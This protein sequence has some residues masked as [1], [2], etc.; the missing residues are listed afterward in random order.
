MCR[1]LE[2]KLEPYWEQG[3]EGSFL[4]S[5][6]CPE[7]KGPFLME[8]GDLL[9]LLSASGELIWSGTFKLRKRRFWEK[10]Q[11]KAG[12]WS[13]STLVGVSYGTWMEWNW[14][15]PRLEAR[16]LRGSDRGQIVYATLDGKGNRP[17]RLRDAGAGR[18]RG[19]KVLEWS[20]NQG[21]YGMGGPGF[22]GLLLESKGPYPREWMTLTL[23]GASEWLILDDDWVAAHPRYYPLRRPLYSDFAEDSWD[24]VTP[25]LV[26]ATLDSIEVERSHF[27]FVL[28]S[29]ARLELPEETGRLPRLGGKDEPRSWKVGEEIR[30]AWVFSEGA[31]YC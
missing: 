29:G 7:V 17:P 23:W 30:D 2:G 12:V 11:L 22:F 3:M 15:Q 5:L 25:I 28:E 27:R 14:S 18:C 20:A 13:T 24:Q 26:G 31:L 16:L 6:S 19:R 21:T 9:D 1:W 10:H 4:Y 8:S